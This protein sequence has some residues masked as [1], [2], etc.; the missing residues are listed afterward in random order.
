MSGQF[1]ASAPVPVAVVANAFS[2]S[3]QYSSSFV[4]PQVSLPH[5]QG[6]IS[7]FC[8]ETYKRS[9]RHPN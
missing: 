1:H 3:Q 8:P 6:R 7:C 5:A 4:E 9:P 2:V